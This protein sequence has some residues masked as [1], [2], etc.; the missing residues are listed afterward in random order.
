MKVALIAPSVFPCPPRGYGGIEALV[1]WLGKELIKLG[2]EVTLIAPK[3]SKLPD[4]QV[5]ET[6]NPPMRWTGVE[7]QEAYKIYKDKL[8]QF[9]IIHDHSHEKWSY[10][11]KLENP[12]LKVISTIHGIQTWQSLPPVT[13]PN[14]VA[15]SKFHSKDMV[16]R[17]NYT[18]KIV[19]HGIP[20]NEYPY[21]EEKTNVILSF[22]LIS[23][24]KGHHI[25]AYLSRRLKFPLLIA[26]EDQFV[27][28][29]EYVD[30]IKKICEANK[31]IMKYKGRMTV[32]EKLLYFSKVK[33]L[34]LPF[35]TD[36]AFSLI[37]IEALA[38]GT[39]VITTNKG[40]MPEI[41]T[42]KQNGFLCQ[43]L[44]DIEKAIKSIY[45]KPI[46]PEK[47]RKT[48]EKKFSSEIMAK[49]YLNLYKQILEGKEW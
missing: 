18:C 26:G 25:S 12:N 32:E 43:T 33:A 38:C 17:Y 37:A 40:A 11:A 9:D 49:N 10:I 36:E 45:E 4:G 16:M 39:P 46:P 13:T 15:I 47:C 28:D 34:L 2:C 41:I 23:K 7:E 8:K 6:I 31:Q 21:Q 35:L 22:G 42:D 30:Y 19:Y 1:Y 3:G 20:V 48:A 29:K 27:T 5:I 24:H 44:E 14:L